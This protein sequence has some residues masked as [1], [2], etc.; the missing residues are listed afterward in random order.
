MQIIQRKHAHMCGTLASISLFALMLSTL[1]FTSPSWMIPFN[2]ICWNFSF[3]MF[4]VFLSCLPGIYYFRSSTQRHTRAR[5]NGERIITD[6]HAFFVH[7]TCAVVVRKGNERVF[8]WFIEPFC[9]E[10]WRQSLVCFWSLK[11]LDLIL[12]PPPPL[13]DDVFPPS[14]E[15]ESL[16]YSFSRKFRVFIK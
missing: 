12:L 2:V 1:S 15:S 10:S 6:I 14:V 7:F 16:F 9:R 13:D 3:F 8:K 11:W 5:W 4:G